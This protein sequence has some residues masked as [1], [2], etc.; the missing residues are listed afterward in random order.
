VAAGPPSGETGIRATAVAIHAGAGVIKSINGWAFPKATPLAEAARL[1]KQAGFEAVEPTL[2]AEGE[3]TPVTGESDCRR[4]G[5]AIRGAGLQVASL[6]TGLFWERNYTSPDPQVRAGAMELT[7]L[8]LQQAQ[9]LGAPVLLVVPGVV[10]HPANPARQVTGYADA[11]HYAYVALRELALD[12]E[13]HGA[14][15]AIENVWNQFLLSPVEMRDFIDRINSPWVGAYLDVGN[16]LKFGFPQDWIEV[17]GGRVV[18]VH[19]KDFKVRVVTK[20]G[21]CGLGEGDVDWPAVMAALRR[22]RYDGPLTYEGRGD[23]ADI[24]QRIDR[25]MAGC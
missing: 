5:D 17:L 12:A 19:L 23:L 24:S 10:G 4:I 15:L 16:V 3:L 11:L 18:R 13:S 21:F 22:Q 6:A 8:G 2:D 20:D 14:I 7:R 9:W 1:A 25:I